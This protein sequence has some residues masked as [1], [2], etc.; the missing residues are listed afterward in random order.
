MVLRG[1][2]P[3]LYLSGWVVFIGHKSTKVRTG[4]HEPLPDLSCPPICW[5]TPH[6]GTWAWDPYQM[7]T[8][9]KPHAGPF[10]SH[11]HL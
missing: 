9:E 5:L 8:E 2:H 6:L 3:K 7:K 4:I 1:T 10:D 11:H